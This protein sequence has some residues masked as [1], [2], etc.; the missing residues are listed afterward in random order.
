MENG[1]PLVDNGRL[2]HIYNITF[3]WRS[4]LKPHFSIRIGNGGQKFS[5]FHVF[6]ALNFNMEQAALLRADP[7]AFFYDYRVISSFRHRNSFTKHI[8][9]VQ[10][11][12]YAINAFL[13]DVFIAISTL[14]AFK[15]KYGNSHFLAGVP[16]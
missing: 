1:I 11:P 12:E 9:M 4:Y 8:K 10:K 16:I 6:V 2:V 3:I 13:Y 15:K 5:F 7:F 14:S